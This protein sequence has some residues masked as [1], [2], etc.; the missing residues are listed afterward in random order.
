V[1]VDVTVPKI[2]IQSGT[3]ILLARPGR[4]HFEAELDERRD[5]PQ[6]TTAAL[7]DGGVWR[8]QRLSR[9]RAAT[10]GERRVGSN[11]RPMDVEED[12]RGGQRGGPPTLEAFCPRYKAD[13]TPR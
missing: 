13:D 3:R 9:Q 12:G 2:G 11:G 8:A 4:D 10:S 1:G 7:H 6:T 5:Q